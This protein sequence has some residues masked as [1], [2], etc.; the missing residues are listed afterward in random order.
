MLTPNKDKRTCS[1]YDVCVIPFYDCL[2]Y[3]LRFHLSFNDFEVGVLNH[4]LI[5]SSHMHLVDWA[6]IKVFPALVQISGGV[7]LVALF[8]LFNF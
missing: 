4:L 3:I 2:F 6:F 5:T 7:D 8:L 1:E